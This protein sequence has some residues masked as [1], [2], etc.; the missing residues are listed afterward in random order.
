MACQIVDA[1]NKVKKKTI[2]AKPYSL[3]SFKMEK[4]HPISCRES[5]YI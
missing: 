5:K 1:S 4:M 2:Y 3:Y